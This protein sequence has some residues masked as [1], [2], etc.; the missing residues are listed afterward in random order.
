MKKKV[1]VVGSI[2]MDI[3]I[4][5]KYLPSPGETITGKNLKYIPGGKGANQAV[6][7]SRLGAT[8]SFIGKVGNDSFGHDLLHFLKAEKLQIAGVT[9]T[10][11]TSG[12]AVIT[13]DDKGEN[14]I[15][16]SPGSN[17]EVTSAYIQRYENV[18]K[19]ADIILAQYE[20]PLESVGTLFELAKKYNKTTVLNPAPAL[21]TPD[22]LFKKVDYLILNETELSFFAHTKSVLTERDEMINAARKLL[23]KGPKNIIVTLGSKGAIAINKNEL[24]VTKGIKVK[25]VDTTAAGDCFVGAL[26]AQLNKNKNLKDSLDFANKAAAL[27]VQKWGASTS[28]PYLKDVSM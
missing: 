25:A 28:I 5:T 19:E 13:V 14:T 3:V 23:K 9:Q 11:L 27:S 12:V 7:A 6:A 8:V 22:K 20:I 21:K 4:G 26:V 2:N 16:V 18:I 10:Q 1:L 15:I 24:I 17:E